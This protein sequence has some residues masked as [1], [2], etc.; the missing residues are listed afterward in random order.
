M[1]AR[2]Q[3]P[4]GTPGHQ[5]VP[6]PGG[7]TSASYPSRSRP[8]EASVPGTLDRNTRDV[9][10]R[11]SGSIDPGITA[12][13]RENPRAIRVPDPS[14]FRQRPA[15]ATDRLASLLAA[16]INPM[17]RPDEQ[18]NG[19]TRPFSSGEWSPGPG[20]GRAQSGDGAAR[21]G[22]GSSHAV[23]HHRVRRPPARSMNPNRLRDTDPQLRGSQ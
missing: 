9:P 19:L 18:V 13:S 21:H 12:G 17:R 6:G 20:R 7:P 2:A 11:G 22:R 10:F 5:V 8:A 16:G 3:G 23:W 15:S 14:A 4:Q 1:V